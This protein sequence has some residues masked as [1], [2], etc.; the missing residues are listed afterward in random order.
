MEEFDGFIFTSSSAQYYAW[1]E[2]NAP[3]LFA[4]IQEQVRRGRWIICGGWW[5]Q[6][7]CNLP[8]GESFVRQGLYGQQY[9]QEKLGVTA[10]VGY[11]VDSF[12]HN[13]NMPQF[14]KKSGMDSYV[15]LRPMPHEL[16]LPK[17]AFQWEGIDGSRVDA[18][19][20]ASNYSSVI[21]LEDHIQ[22]VLEF[23]PEDSDHFVCFYGVGNHGGG[24]TI[25]NIEHILKHM[26]L[27]EGL[28]MEFSSPPAYFAEVRK[29]G[30]PLPVV[31]GELQHHAPGCY[32]VVAK[33]KG[34]I[35]EA[36]HSL[37]AAEVFS[38]LSQNMQGKIEKPGIL[39]E[40]WKATLAT[41]FH[42]VIAGA[43][44]DEVC[45][46]AQ[47][48]LG[49]A[50]TSANR[51]TNSALQAISFA[52]D[53]PYVE[54]D[55]PIVVFNPHSFPVRAIVGHEKGSWHV[56]GFHEPFQVV[57]SKNELV[58]FQTVHLT[59]QLDERTR[60]AFLAEL[61]PMGYET[62]RIVK[63]E[64]AREADVSHPV[65]ILEN[66][67]VR[68]VLDPETG[69]L[70]SYYDKQMDRELLGAPSGRFV[71][72]NDPTDTW[73]HGSYSFYGGG[74]QAEFVSI[75][76]VEDGEL[77]QRV[78]VRFRV[79]NSSI[80]TVY[81]LKKEDKALDLEIKVNWQEHHTC[82]K[83]YTDLAI[84]APTATWE[85][86]F[87]AAE[88]IAD[89]REEPMQSWV[90]VS[91]EDHGVAFAAFGLGGGHVLE[92]SVGL[93][94]LRS[95]AFSHHAP[96]PLGED[97]ELYGYTDQGIQKY[98]I[99]LLPHAGGWQD[100]DICQRALLLNRPVVKV[101]E[102]FHNGTLPRRYSGIAIDQPNILLSTLK[103]AYNGDGL[104]LRLWEAFGKETN[105]T[106]EL[107]LLG[108]SF[109]AR[110]T[111]FEVKTFRLRPGMP[112]EEC[113]MTEL[114]G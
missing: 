49:G 23:Y 77:L 27:T 96:H 112:E 40:P 89:G 20:I 14:L 60:I 6:P 44:V 9:F 76:R 43:C 87:G 3:D 31:K 42:D 41:Q 102:T 107:P 66:E 114:D 100:S 88:R 82:L 54:G 36:E 67:L 56:F 55:Q 38:V 113:L 73:G 50:I 10:T 95:P 4:R 59:A 16:P 108:S 29:E 22:D 92:G 52:V 18:C 28:R 37:C 7:D 17:G 93:T 91:R 80:Q 35:R 58:P 19:R 105:A 85:I 103:N 83:F 72:H 111:P 34:L 48:T 86:P 12:G 26:Q 74:K 33:T 99:Q 68:I 78:Q 13:G 1:I 53:I 109:Q 104:I 110:F 106:V 62:Y 15:F 39:D 11:N 8:T 90:D 65:N 21:G 47:K 45:E 63:A 51:V 32:S 2:E 97:P 71:A 57:N 84:A 81:S 69:L 70:T 5:V 98:R 64:K 61:P 30:H 24:P 94:L 79:G 75:H 46:D 25:A 101:T